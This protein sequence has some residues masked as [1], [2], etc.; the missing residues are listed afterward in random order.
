MLYPYTTRIYPRERANVASSLPGSLTLLFLVT[1]MGKRKGDTF[2]R[3]LPG[4][5]VS[6]RTN[7]RLR[8]A[9][10]SGVLALWAWKKKKEQEERPRQRQQ[11]GMAIEQKQRLS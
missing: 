7:I 11:A 4:R 2:D 3:I 8:G 10:I 9:L 6:T 1:L 5:L